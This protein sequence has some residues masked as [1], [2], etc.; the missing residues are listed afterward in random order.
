MGKKK[1]EP[2]FI[3]FE[4]YSVSKNKD[5]LIKE[6]IET[7]RKLESTSFQELQNKNAKW[8]DEGW[9]KVNYGCR[10]ITAKPIQITKTVDGC[11][12]LLENK[13]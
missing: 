4:F 7:A 2:D 10:S 11:L 5:E 3:E 9:C 8:L 12:D 13:K 6:L 1:K